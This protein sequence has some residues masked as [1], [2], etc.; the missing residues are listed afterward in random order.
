VRRGCRKDQSENIRAVMFTL[1]A[2]YRSS[3]MLYPA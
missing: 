1:P 2:L 3:G